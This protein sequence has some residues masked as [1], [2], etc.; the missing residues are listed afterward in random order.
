MQGRPQVRMVPGRACAGSHRWAFSSW[1]PCSYGFPGGPPAC[2]ARP[3]P[4]CTKGQ[5]SCPP[6]PRNPSHVQARPP[7]ASQRQRVWAQPRHRCTLNRWPSSTC[8]RSRSVPRCPCPRLARRPWPRTPRGRSPRGQR[9]EGRCGF[10]IPALTFPALARKRVRRAHLR[11][12]RAAS[13]RRRW[14]VRSTKR[15]QRLWRNPR[16]PWWRV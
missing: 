13:P 14:R 3:R 16:G 7:P 2:G 8:R 6:L 5:P 11:L 4:H 10:P 12:F 1:L 15:P 9:R